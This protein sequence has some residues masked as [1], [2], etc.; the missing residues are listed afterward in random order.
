MLITAARSGVYRRNLVLHVYPTPFQLYRPPSCRCTG[1]PIWRLTFSPVFRLGP[2]GPGTA[3]RSGRGARSSHSFARFRMAA[4]CA[5][6]STE[7][8]PGVDWRPL[9]FEH[10]LPPNWVCQLCGV[11]SKETAKLLCP[12]TLCNVCFE[13]SVTLGCVCPLDRDVFDQERVDK[14]R[15]R[16]GQ[17]LKLRVLCWN[18]A[19]GCN[20]VGPVAEFLDHFEK[21]C[22][23]HTASCPGC[24]AKPRAALPQ[25]LQPCQKRA[26]AAVRY[27]LPRTAN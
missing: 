25:R 21:D 11:V 2:Q 26:S 10:P 17:L 22:S 6:L 27:E 14:L 20:F 15:L 16:P 5:T 9:H 18:S 23:R 1:A 3:A 7:F 8:L 13:T 12:H 4:T 24:A 19:H